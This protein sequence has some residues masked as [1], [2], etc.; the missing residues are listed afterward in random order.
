M[1]VDNGHS[2]MTCLLG[3]PGK[4]AVYDYGLGQIAKRDDGTLAYFDSRAEA[5]RWRD[6]TIRREGYH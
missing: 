4:W 1:A 6:E 2:T 5:K 3:V